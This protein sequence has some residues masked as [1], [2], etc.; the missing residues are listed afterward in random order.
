MLSINQLNAQIKLMEIWK[1]TNIDDYPLKLNRK[2]VL[3][4]NI[5][6]RAFS[7]GRLII[8]GSKPV[9]QKTCVTYAISGTLLLKKLRQHCLYH[10]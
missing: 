5:T 1:A 9:M 2:E 10:S 6:T 8:P 4:D 7:Q 3:L